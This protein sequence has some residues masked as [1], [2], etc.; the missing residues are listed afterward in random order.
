MV[1]TPATFA[2]GVQIPPTFVGFMTVFAFV[3]DR[4]IQPGFGFFDRMTA[5]VSFVGMHKGCR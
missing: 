5:L 4:F 2:L 3:A 1:S